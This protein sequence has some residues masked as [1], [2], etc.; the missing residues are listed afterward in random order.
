M[1]ES[2]YIK[3]NRYKSSLRHVAG[4]L[5]Q[6]RDTQ[7]RRAKTRTRVIQQQRRDI[8]LRERELADVQFELCRA[9]AEI[10]ELKAENSRLRESA[11]LP[12][13]PALPNHCYGARMISLCVNLATTVG[14]RA[15]EAAL[16]LFF[17]WIGVS[18]KVPDWTTIRGWLCR[19]G[20]AALQA[21]VERADDWIWLADHSNQIGTEKVLVILGVR[22]SQLPEPG[23]PLR[24]ED[25]RPLA[26]IPGTDWK[27][28]DVT[29]EYVALAERIGEPMALLVDGAVELR[30]GAQTLEK[31]GKV[32]LVL[33][34]F[35]HHAANILKRLVG[36]D[37]RFSQFLTLVGRTRAGIQQTE[38]SHLT[39]P[40]QKPKARFMN[41]AATLRWA[42]MVLWQLS[43]PRSDGRREISINR[44]NE[45]LG[46]LRSFRDD[47]RRWSICQ[48]I[49]SRSLT[50]INQH[51]LYVGAAEDLTS[52]LIDLGSHELGRQMIDQLTQFTADS[53]KQLTDSMRV[54]M[55]TEILESSFGRYKAL[56]KQHSKGGFTGLLAAFGS[57]LRRSTP[58][59]IKEN[60]TRVLTKDVKAWI[61][62]NLKETLASR[63][64]AAYREF[65]AA[66]TA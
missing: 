35:K 44:M 46:W 4:F 57:L 65:L 40:P 24:H 7:A 48:E 37:E 20:I 5:L 56:E 32:V 63:R 27:R 30:D 15:A 55:S 2:S 23:Q 25:V 33:R 3:A 49:V 62:E 36:D 6:S 11:L 18:T 17:D 1:V 61:Q 19:V 58:E 29:R 13:D 14:L 9:R 31:E 54:P 42:E 39:P 59:T 45:K 52:L 8:Q 50:F 47:V 51:G 64:Q 34:D 10:Q 26:V 16:K 12:D 43:N 53:E 60:F 28:E 41:M 22:A 38:L 66:Q 21:P